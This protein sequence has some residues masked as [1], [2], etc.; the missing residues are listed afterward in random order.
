MRATVEYIKTLFNEFNELCFDGKLPPLP[1]EESHARNFM[2]VFRWRKRIGEDGTEEPY[3]MQLRISTVYDMEE[4]VVKDTILHEMIHYYITYFRIK[5]TSPH[6]EVFIKMMNEINTKYG[7]HISVK[8]DRNREIEAT[9]TEKKG[10]FICLCE[11]GFDLL[12][13]QCAKTRILQ[14]YQELAGDTKIGKMT[15]YYTENPFFNKFPN[16]SKARLLKV[17]RMELIDNLAGAIELEC[18]GRTLRQ[19]RK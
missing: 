9:D 2:G 13:L 12:F 7:R 14:I 17:N 5:D 16:S 10:H 15:W 19:K 1:I 6:G 3:D 8:I 4:E 18:D 11:I